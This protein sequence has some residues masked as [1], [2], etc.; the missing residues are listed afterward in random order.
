MM[1]ML[2]TL[3]VERFQ[4]RLRRETR[5]VSGYALVLAKGEPKLR[6]HGGASPSDCKHRMDS[7]GQLF[8]ENC[9]LSD[10]VGTNVLYS[11]LGGSFVA[12]ET[13]L[14]G[15]YDFELMASWELPANPREGRQEPRVIKCWASFNIHRNRAFNSA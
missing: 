4:L 14:S 12:D 10:L 11:I 1:L 9:P 3:L 6:Q 8:F 7:G 13:G 5:E 15:T 2:Q